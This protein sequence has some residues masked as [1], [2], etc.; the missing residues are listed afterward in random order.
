MTPPTFMQC[1]P[2]VPQAVPTLNAAWLLAPAQGQRGGARQAKG[3]R[4]QPGGVQRGHRL[5]R[6]QVDTVG[7]VGHALGGSGALVYGTAV[8]MGPEVPSA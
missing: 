1:N 3:Q 4:Q 6:W 7:W 8:V 5:G 2:P